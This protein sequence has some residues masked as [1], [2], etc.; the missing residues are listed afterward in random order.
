MCVLLLIPVLRARMVQ[1]QRLQAEAH[2]GIANV[3][4]S[5][6]IPLENREATARPPKPLH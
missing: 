6:S 3:G 4:M 2:R 1:L 5:G